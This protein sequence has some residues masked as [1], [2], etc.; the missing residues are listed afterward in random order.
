MTHWIVLG[1]TEILVMPNDPSNPLWNSS[2]SG[3]TDPLALNFDSTASFND[4]SCFYLVSNG[5]HMERQF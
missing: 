4:G 5:I 3:C 1:P 2:C